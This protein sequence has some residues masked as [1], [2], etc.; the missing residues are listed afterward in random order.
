MTGA[1]MTNYKQGCQ[2]VWGGLWSAAIFVRASKCQNPQ[3]HK[4]R[5]LKAPKPANTDNTPRDERKTK[6]SYLHT[7]WTRQLTSASWIYIGGDRDGDYDGCGDD[8][9]HNGDDRDAGN[10][11]LT[12]TFLQCQG[13]SSQESFCEWIFFTD[14]FYWGV[15]MEFEL[16]WKRNSRSFKEKI[17]QKRERR[18]SE[19][20][21]MVGIRSGPFMR[22]ARVQRIH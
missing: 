3:I 8:G 16:F 6:I 9:F 20:V 15:E 21:D 12:F 7:D 22:H 10:D 5:Q 13:L 17:D 2:C 11:F 18:T 14:Y 19:R 1:R 4:C